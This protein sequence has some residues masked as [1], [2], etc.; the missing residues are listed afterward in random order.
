MKKQNSFSRR[1][2]VKS[3][4]LGLLAASVPNIVY[5][6]NILS[7]VPDEGSST[8]T[9]HD[10]YPAI[11]LTIASEVVGVAHFNLDRLK[12]LVDPRPELAKAEWDWGYG[13][14]ESALGAASHVG[15]KDIIEYLIGKG[16]VP[17]IFTYAMLGH[18]E[19]VKAMITSYPGIQKNF[20]PHGITL[21]QHARNGA[22]TEGIDKS[23]AKQL[24]E[25]LQSLGDADGRPYLNLDETEKTKYLGDYKYGEGKEDGF[26]I[27][28]NMRKLLSLG[29]LG[30]S[31]G[32]LWRIGEQEF[33]YQG[34]PSVTV[35]FLVQNARVHALTVNEPG[36]ILTATKI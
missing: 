5:S 16:A 13:D 3:S 32:A 30:K 19:T 12:E 11:Q 35:K 9:P 8:T 2:L 34:A 10:R 22:E 24:I 14:W 6:K 23:K 20:G 17:T 4:V 31:G 28:L 33:T 18:Y 27:K 15:R 25:Y 36:L 1:L 21:L 26:T 7:D 29:K